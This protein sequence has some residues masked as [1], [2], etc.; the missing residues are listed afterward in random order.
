[1]ANQRWYRT[2]YF[3]IFLHSLVWTAFIVMP[4]FLREST[5]NLANLPA[6]IQAKMR[7]LRP[8]FKVT[9]LYN[10]INIAFFY[11]NA[12]VLMPFLLGRKKTIQY[13]LI[14][15]VTFLVFMYS[16]YYL[17]VT[18]TNSIF[19][20]RFP[21]Y[22]FFNL[23]LFLALSIVY[24]FVVD[25]NRTDSIQR[26]KETINLK[27]ELSFLRSQVSPHFMF[28]V[29]NNIVALSRTQPAL[30]EPSLIQLSQLMR[31]MLYESNEDKVTLEKELEYLNNYIQLQLM[32]FGDDIKVELD[33]EGEADGHL[34][35]PML[36]V[37]FVENAFKHGSCLMDQPH[38]KIQIVINKGTLLFEVCNKFKKGSIEQK[39]K[40][41]GIG[42]QNVIRRLNLLYPRHHELKKFENGA[43]Y[44]VSLTLELK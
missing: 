12:F 21:I 5:E 27:T 6:S 9:V 4:Y 35:E 15:A 8:P 23:M 13:I 36:L 26:E 33:Q 29:L 22:I 30:V 44:C 34:I 18:L 32:R 39:D 43:Y 14:T 28:N 25:K 40:H 7:Y 19:L 11:L 2:I 16:V 37:P 38:I 1:M 41:S 42:L 17:R 24:R 31:Y 10:L 20:V 3:S